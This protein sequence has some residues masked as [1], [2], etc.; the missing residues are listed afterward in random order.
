MKLPEFL[1]GNALVM[2]VCECIWRSTVDIVV[3]FV[4]LYV[5]EL[6]GSYQTIG[7]IMS[8]ASL[9]SMLLY[10]LGGYIADY[11]GRIK[12]IGYMTFMYAF[13]FLVTGLGDSWQWL[14]LGMF[15]QNLTTFYWPAIQALMADSI[16]PYQRGMGYATVEAIP[17]AFG[18]IAPIAGAFF[19]GVFGMRTA[20]RG[21]Y[22]SSFII[23]SALALFRLRFLKETIMNPKKLDTSVNGVVQLFTNS[24]R[25]VFTMISDISREVWVF[26][27]LV[28]AM[29]FSASFASSFWI[30]RVTQVLGLSLSE[31]ATVIMLSGVVG[32]VLG[33]PAGRFTDRVPKRLVAGACMILDACLA[34]V[35]L[36]VST[37]SEVLALALVAAV[38]DSFL[39]PSLKS[40]I[41]DLIPRGVRGRAMALVGGG[42]LNLMRNV[43]ATGILSKIFLTVGAFMSGYIY[44][45]GNSLPWLILSGTLLVIGILFIIVVRDPAKP[46]V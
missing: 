37:Y 24:Y 20:M 30:I 16:P 41:A 40:I 7:Y 23:A 43:Q 34:F 26:T 39:N 15:L 28:T 13:A 2:T 19:I 32:V 11:Q 3:P 21:L 38:V 5:L 46:E 31:W 18:L 33:I 12:L 35:F 8:G 42:G 29:V 9:A 45:V 14:A 17:S 22:L 27:L 1:R 6:G 44:G 4:S 25:E 36:R 10:P